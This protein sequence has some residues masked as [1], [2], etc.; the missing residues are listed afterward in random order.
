MQLKGKETVY[1]RPFKPFTSLHIQAHINGMLED[2][3][4]NG[5]LFGPFIHYVI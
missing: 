5:M 3:N 1:S 4:H 2:P